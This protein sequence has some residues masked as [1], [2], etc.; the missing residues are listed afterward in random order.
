MLV[1]SLFV[2]GWTILRRFGAPA[3][4]LGYIGAIG[5][6]VGLLILLGEALVL[7]GNWKWFPLGLALSAGCCAVG[8]AS[9]IRRIRTAEPGLE[10]APAGRRPRRARLPADALHDTP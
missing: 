1:F 9:V 6:S 8:T 3:S 4:L 2:P 10:R 7:F 5:L